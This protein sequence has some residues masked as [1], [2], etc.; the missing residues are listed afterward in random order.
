MRDAMGFPMIPATRITLERTHAQLEAA[1]DPAEFAM[2][3]QDGASLAMEEILDMV[4]DHEA[5]R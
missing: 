1:L 4:I 3:L 2:L 5:S